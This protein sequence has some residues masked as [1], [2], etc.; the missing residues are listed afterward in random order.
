[1]ASTSEKCTA[2]SQWQ[3]EPHSLCCEGVSAAW[4]HSPGCQGEGKGG[5]GGTAL[6]VCP[7]NAGLSQMMP[8]F[9]M[10]HF[11]IPSE[12]MI[13]KGGHLG[14]GNLPWRLGHTDS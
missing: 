1:M 9:P 8:S 11:L 14:L 12:C 5:P 3:G 13:A 2:L 4:T 6:G 7:K 10:I